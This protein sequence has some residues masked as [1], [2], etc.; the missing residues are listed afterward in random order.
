MGKINGWFTFY[1]SG[2]KKPKLK[3]IPP[4][5][6][7]SILVTFGGGILFYHKNWPDYYNAAVTPI[8]LLFESTTRRECQS[9]LIVL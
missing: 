4:M 1:H 5:G 2:P 3:S 7:F 8:L 6:Y 9:L